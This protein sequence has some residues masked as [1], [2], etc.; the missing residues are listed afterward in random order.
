MFG[1][2]TITLG[3][4]PH[5]SRFVFCID[6]TDDKIK[7]CGFCAA[8]YHQCVCLDHANASVEAVRQCQQL[9]QTATSHVTC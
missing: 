3:I 6:V 5:S 4:G 2:A 1:C 9:Q 7:W 8:V